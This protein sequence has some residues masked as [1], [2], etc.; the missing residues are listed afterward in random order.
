M[1]GERVFAV[2]GP[3]MA[4]KTTLLKATALAVYLAHLGCGVPARRARLPYF[5]A[6]FA[7]LYVR[8]S[9]ARAESFYLSEVRRIRDLLELL[10]RA[11]HV[12]AVVDEPFKGT[13]IHDASDA[14][15]LL[16]DGLCGL[17][18]ATAMV[19]THLADTVRLRERSPVLIPVSLGAIHRDDG[20]HFEFSLRR[21]V[22][23][24]RLGMELLRREGVAAL[25]EAAA[26]GRAD[27]GTMSA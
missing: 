27:I 16:L 9:L 24:Q 2:T 15:G 11:P 18:G 10:G 12:F 20:L 6:L 22:S 23:D 21:G 5:D 4:G 14:T 13:N 7:S 8:D 26:A 17:P 1:S 25:L 3:N 19:A